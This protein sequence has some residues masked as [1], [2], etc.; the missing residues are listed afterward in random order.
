MRSRDEKYRI[1]LNIDRERIRTIVA[2]A[3]RTCAEMLQIEFLITEEEFTSR[4]DPFLDGNRVS[5]TFQLPLPSA[6]YPEMLIEINPRKPSVFARIANRSRQ[7]FV[8][9]FLT[10]L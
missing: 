1:H 3:Y 7:A 5:T 8:N 6:A 9:R 10:K 4:V 2:E